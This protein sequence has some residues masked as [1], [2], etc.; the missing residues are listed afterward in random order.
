MDERQ[1]QQ[2]EEQR[3]QEELTCKCGVR[4]DPRP[5]SLTPQLCGKCAEEVWHYANVMNKRDRERPKWERELA[6]GERDDMH[7]HDIW[8]KS[9]WRR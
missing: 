8:D 4:F 1:Q 7:G 9:G 5:D 6:R 2:L 3:Q